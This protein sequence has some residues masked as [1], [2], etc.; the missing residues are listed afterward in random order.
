MSTTSFPS[1]PLPSP[2]T[3]FTGPDTPIPP[4]EPACDDKDLDEDGDV[5]AADYAKFQVCMSGSGNPVP[6]GC[7]GLP[8]TGTFAMHGLT[9]DVL[10]D[11]H[12]LVYAR[13]RHYDPRLGRWLQRDPKGYVDGPNAYE[14][15]GGNPIAHRD[16]HGKSVWVTAEREKTEHNGRPAWSVKYVRHTTGAHLGWRYRPGKEVTTVLGES[17][18]P[19]TGDDDFYMIRRIDREVEAN[20]RAFDDMAT[21]DWEL[22]ATE[23]HTRITVVTVVAISTAGLGGPAIAGAFGATPVGLG[24]ATVPLGSSI[25]ATSFT[26]FI[27]LGVGSAVGEGVLGGN[28][29]SIAMEGMRGAAV[30]A[31][32]GGV[33]GA[34][35][36][37]GLA[38]APSLQYARNGL[39]VEARSSLVAS[40]TGNVALGQ[41]LRH[42]KIWKAN[43]GIPGKPTLPQF[44]RFMGAHRP[45]SRGVT[46]YPANTSGFL[47]WSR[48]AGQIHRHHGFPQQFADDFLDIGISNID[49]FIFDLP[50]QHHLGKVHAGRAGG[51]YN[52]WWDEFFQGK[53]GDP[54]APNALRWLE[55]HRANRFV[56]GQ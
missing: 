30:G 17:F 27:S 22:A 42:Y 29:R 35:I 9:L 31:V 10:P 21:A 6:P 32:L 52:R 44:R 54:T 55:I 3:G 5:D 28:A 38:T 33:E 26:G 4:G 16:P 24:L 12:V 7:G 25:A 45:G 43:A 18:Y 34:I 11:G 19:Y 1:P 56:V 41:R 15:F 50:A 49:D 40:D 8:D 20:R 23:I 37:P 47:K 46:L 51:A 48:T 14:A 53:Y 39:G 2:F 36:R 13:A